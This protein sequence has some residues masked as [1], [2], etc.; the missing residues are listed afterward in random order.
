M[1]FSDMYKDADGVVVPIP[2]F[3]FCNTVNKLVKAEPAP[4]PT[5]F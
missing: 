1:V 4:A 3:P 5:G 2:T